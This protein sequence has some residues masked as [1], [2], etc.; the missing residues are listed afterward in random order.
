MLV[1]WTHLCALA[2]TLGIAAGGSGLKVVKSK[3][4]STKTATVSVCLSSLRESKQW[5]E[6]K[7]Q[8]EIFVDSVSGKHLIDTSP[9]PLPANFDDPWAEPKRKL[10]PPENIA[11]GELQEK[12]APDPEVV[13]QN[14]RREYNHHRQSYG[15]PN[16]KDW[17]QKW[18]VFDFEAQ[19]HDCS[20]RTEKV[21]DFLFAVRPHHTVFSMMAARET[22][23]LD[24]I[25]SHFTQFIESDL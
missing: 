13:Q 5:Y 7:R 14:I 21:Q 11:N 8:L 17:L 16:L 12:V 19:Q 18:L 9:N 1:L 22:W 20:F 3:A 15:K 25:V 10:R 6:W 23:T 4:G 2:G 24:S